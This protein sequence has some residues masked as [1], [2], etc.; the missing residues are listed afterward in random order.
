MF[1]CPRKRHSKTY[2]WYIQERTIG[3]IQFV[4]KKASQCKYDWY[5]P[6]FFAWVGHE[7]DKLPLFWFCER[8]PRLW[9]D[10]PLIVQGMENPFLLSLMKLLVSK[11]YWNEQFNL[12]INTIYSFDELKQKTAVLS[13]NCFVRLRGFKR[14]EVTSG[15]H[16]CW[17]F[18]MFIWQQTDNF[19]DYVIVA[20]CSNFRHN[21]SCWTFSQNR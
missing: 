19:F 6:G 7:C 11:F 13:W 20:W 1:K 16:H 18:E 21:R 12:K 15:C 4:A 14:P 2:L 17:H 5:F 10:T 3:R 9:I 8:C